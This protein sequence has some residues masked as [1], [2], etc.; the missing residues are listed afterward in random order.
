MLYLMHHFTAVQLYKMALETCSNHQ[1]YLEFVSSSNNMQIQFIAVFVSIIALVGGQENSQYDSNVAKP[2]Y[3]Q[4]APMPHSFAWAVKDEPSKNDYSH[5]Q[6]S[7][8]KV[9]TGSYRVVLPDGR[10]Q[11]VAYRADENGY[12]A[13]VKYEGE[14]RYPEYKPSSYNK[15]AEYPTSSEAAKPEYPTV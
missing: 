10:T 15:P 7:D 1:F 6:E 9:T 5:Q 4:K 13:D 3:E 8:G 14:A 2:S 12:V 11:I